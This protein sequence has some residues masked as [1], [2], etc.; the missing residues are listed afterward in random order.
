MP[1]NPGVIP[2]DQPA[3]TPVPMPSPGSAPITMQ[4]GT[5]VCDAA[6]APMVPLYSNVIV[7]D[8]RN[9]APCAVKKI[10]AVPD[11]CNPCCC[12]YVC[13][14]VPP[15]AC[16][17][18]YCSPHKDRVVFDYGQYAVKITARRDMLVVNY[19]D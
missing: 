15:C 16:E 1:P 14:C 3:L 17:S 9:I 7:R 13:I 4:P 18:V 10:V 8:A 2:G 5:I 12:V 6:L 11:P 19:D